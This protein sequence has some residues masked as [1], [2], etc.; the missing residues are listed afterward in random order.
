MSTMMTGSETPGS[1][2]CVTQLIPNAI[3]AACAARIATADTPQRRM[4]A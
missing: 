3:N 2:R 1:G 4:V